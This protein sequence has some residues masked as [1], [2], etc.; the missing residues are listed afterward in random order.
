MDPSVLVSM[1]VNAAI[2][3]LLSLIPISLM[4]AILRY[5]LWGIDLLINRTLVYVPLT[6]IL[7][8]I[9]AACISLSQKLSAA[10]TG[11]QSDAA[12]VLTTLIV[13]AAFDPLKHGLQQLVDKRFKET[14]DAAE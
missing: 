1:I 11:Q 12:T 14:P 4:I 9:F 2:L 8:G 7:A 5:R 10:L 6:A 3:L 13:V